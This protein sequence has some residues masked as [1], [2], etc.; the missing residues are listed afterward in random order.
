M[1][2]N[3]SMAF[4]T[5]NKN[6]LIILFIFRLALVQAA[7]EKRLILSPQRVTELSGTEVRKVLLEKK[8][9]CAQIVHRAA[10]GLNFRYYI[11]RW[12]ELLS[13]RVWGMWK[14]H[15]LSSVGLDAPQLWQIDCVTTGRVRLDAGGGHF[16]GKSSLSW[17]MGSVGARLFAVLSVWETKL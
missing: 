3:M 14:W 8:I 11:S 2:K 6:L 10:K 1:K 17:I 16:L 5:L 9:M 7:S 4:L 12:G 13:L 15:Q